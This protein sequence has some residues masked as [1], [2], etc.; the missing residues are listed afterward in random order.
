[1]TI[2]RLTSPVAS[3]SNPSFISSNGMTP[4]NKLSIVSIIPPF[5]TRKMIAC[6][7]KR[8]KGSPAH[9]PNQLMFPIISATN[10]ALE[11][12]MKN[13]EFREDL[14]YRIAVITLDTPP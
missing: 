9:N 10:Q 5:T 11:K 7:G 12:K 14:F 13:G 8:Y 3:W 6:P 2:I 1:M 4:L